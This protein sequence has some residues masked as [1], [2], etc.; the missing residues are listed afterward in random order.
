VELLGRRFGETWLDGDRFYHDF[1]Q[2][3]IVAV[4]GLIA[5]GIK[6]VQSLEDLAKDRVLA[7]ELRQ[8]GEADIELAT[9]RN[10][11][12]IDVVGQ[13]RH[14]H[15][16]ADMTA[17]KFGRYCKARSTGAGTIFG[18]TPA[19]RIAGLDQSAGKRAMEAHTIVEA[20]STKLL[21]VRHRRG[22]GV[23]IE[24][25]NDLLQISF[26]ADLDLHDSY[27]GTNRGGEPAGEGYKDKDES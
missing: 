18:S 9:I 27:L 17:S 3:K 22:C 24:T 14:G 15:R 5:D 1:C 25:N 2:W 20:L 13:T 6:H 21:E 4:R 11:R 12:W 7:I 26:L 8:R 10:L 19:S 23:I 16:A